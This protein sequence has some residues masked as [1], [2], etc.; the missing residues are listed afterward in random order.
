MNLYK[1]LHETNGLLDLV[2]VLSKAGC[3]KRWNL[4]GAGY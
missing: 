4:E 1:E 3:D 2:L